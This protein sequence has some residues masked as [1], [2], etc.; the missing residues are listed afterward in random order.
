MG[1]QF[2]NDKVL[3]TASD[4]VAFGCNVGG[5]CGWCADGAPSSLQVVLSGIIKGEFSECEECS[6]LDGTYVLGRESVEL[7]NTQCEW[8]FEGTTY[9]NHFFKLKLTLSDDSFLNYRMLVDYS[10]IGG[11]GSILWLID[12]VDKFPCLDLSDYSV[13][14]LSNSG[15]SICDG[16]SSTCLVSAI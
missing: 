9:C 5:P 1:V 4:K 12:V 10:D 16:G 8:V 14:F 13:P 6:S 2:A 7:P 15:Q 11:G 3:F